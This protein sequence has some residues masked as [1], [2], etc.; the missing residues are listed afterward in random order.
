MVNQI[1][2]LVLGE[3]YRARTQIKNIA[4]KLLSQHDLT[5]RQI[6][7]IVDFLTEDSGSHDY[8]IN[9]KEARD[10]LFLPVETPDDK[11]YDIIKS[12]FDDIK[13]ELE[14][15]NPYNPNSLFGSSMGQTAY[16]LRQAL[17]ESIPIKSH[18]FIKEGIM[19]KISNQ[20]PMGF[21]QELVNDQIIFQGWRH[22]F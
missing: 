19:T 3:T 12:I 10:N 2:P 6:N 13:E 15:N 5:K 4:K 1:H 11:L 17:I 16:S 14:L 22:E 21:Q 18:V 20:N 9:R 7:K 8:T